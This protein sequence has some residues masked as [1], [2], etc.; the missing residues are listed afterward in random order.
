MKIASVEPFVW[1]GWRECVLVRVHTDEGLVGVGEGTCGTRTPSI[2]GAIQELKQYLV[3]QDPTCIEHLWQTM[4]RAPFWRQGAAYVSAVSAIDIALWDILGKVT[5][6]PIYKLLGGPTRRKIKV[7]THIHSWSQLDRLD[8]GKVEAE[9]VGLK[10]RGFRAFKVPPFEA[11][12][13]VPSPRVIRNAIDRI[14]KLRQLIG[15][16]CELM[17]DMHG[18]LTH[19][20]SRIAVQ[21]LE[22]MDI[23]FV[24]EPCWPEYPAGLAEVRAATTIPI[25][26][27]ER[28]FTKWQWRQVLEQGCVS[29]AQP[30]VCR[31]GGI[32]ETRRIAAMCEA[33]LVPLAPHSPMSA[34]SNLACLHIDAAI[35]NFVIQ[36]MVS[37]SLGDGLIRQPIRVED[38]YAALPAG[39]GLGAELI[40]D[41]EMP[42]ENKTM[43]VPQF[44]HE[45][46][47]VAD[48]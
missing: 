31:A 26:A 42:C 39:P 18:R 1:R 29:V 48:W 28:V 13:H 43:S 34:I 25:A 36:E 17:L 47:S 41:E 38:G 27:G 10:Q 35:A 32:S 6:L 44:F 46:G 9:L 20:A 8:Y 22:G 19:T 12:D 15:P 33:Y 11:T 3:G 23:L 45:D 16:E 5:G 7:Y 30:D 24:E 37:R 14:A 40:P 2:M 21:M 4:Y